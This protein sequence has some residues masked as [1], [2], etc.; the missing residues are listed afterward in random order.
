MEALFNCRRINC[1][2]C[3]NDYTDASLTITVALWISGV[4]VAY[5]LDSIVLLGGN[6]VTIRTAQGLAFTCLAF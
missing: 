1:L 6:L 2:A 5:I 3:V 4:Q